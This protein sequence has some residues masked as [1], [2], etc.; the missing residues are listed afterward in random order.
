MAAAPS[1]AHVDPSKITHNVPSGESGEESIIASMAARIVRL[2]LRV[3]VL[4]HRVL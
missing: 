1:Q 3:G 2:R 4:V